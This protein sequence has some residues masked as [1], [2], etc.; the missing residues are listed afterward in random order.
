MDI[1]ECYV[2]PEGETEYRCLYRYNITE[3]EYTD[4]NYR[5]IGNFEKVN[6]PS[7][8]LKTLL[9]RSGVPQGILKQFEKEDRK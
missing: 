3:N 9:T 2:S 6:P 4:G 8:H 1:S 7:E 5:I